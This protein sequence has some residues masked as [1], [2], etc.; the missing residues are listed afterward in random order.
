[1]A[2]CGGF[3]LRNATFVRYPESGVAGKLR[4]GAFGQNASPVY[5]PPF[6]EGGGRGVGD[7]ESEDICIAIYAHFFSES[8]ELQ[9][10]VRFRQERIW[11]L[12]K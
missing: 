1:M 6:N 3:A 9:K 12:F 7:C 11:A 5:R 10:S 8:R 2:S 4:Q